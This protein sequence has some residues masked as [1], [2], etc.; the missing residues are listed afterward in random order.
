MRP[1]L[2][3]SGEV[4]GYCLKLFITNSTT[5]S[6]YRISLCAIVFKVVDIYVKVRLFESFCGSMY[7]CELWSLE[8]DAVE[9]VCRS[10]MEISSQT[11]IKFDKYY[12][13]FTVLTNTLPV[14]DEIYKRLA[15]FINMCI[16]SRYHLKYAP[17]I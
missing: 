6:F 14:F 8:H 9:D 11:I 4:D 7:C 2:V 15:R 16:N 3:W 5:K 13:M 1:Q 12:I 17:F 10:C